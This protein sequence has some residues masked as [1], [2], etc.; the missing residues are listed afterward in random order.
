[1]GQNFS[2]KWQFSLATLLIIFT[3]SSTAFIYF[4]PERPPK[5]LVPTNAIEQQVLKL[6]EQDMPSNAEKWVPVSINLEQDTESYLVSYWTPKKEL[7]LLGPRQAR[8]KLP[9]N[10]TYPPRD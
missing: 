4:Q 3:V 8:V 9:D 2:R 5:P 7:R 10:V 6:V 1:M